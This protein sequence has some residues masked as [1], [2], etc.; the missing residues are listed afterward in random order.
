[1]FIGEKLSIMDNANIFTNFTLAWFAI[2]FFC[3]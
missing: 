3:N 1:M 2:I